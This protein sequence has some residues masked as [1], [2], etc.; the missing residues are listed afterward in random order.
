LGFSRGDRDENIRRIGYVC[1]LLSK[2]GVGVI[3]AAISPYRAVRDEVRAS[4]ANF[5]E[6]YVK[7]PLSVCMERDPKGMYKRAL[8]GEIPNFTG[9]SDPY[10]EPHAPEIV[11]ETDRKTPEDCLAL[12]LARLRELGLI[13]GQGDFHSEK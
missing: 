12:I 3:A 2:H 10:E 4:V 11:V 5:V 13:P 1:R 8:A 6:V 9:I 7:A